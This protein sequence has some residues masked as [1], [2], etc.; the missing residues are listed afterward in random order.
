MISILWFYF[1]LSD[2]VIQRQQSDLLF[3]LYNISY[4]IEILSLKKLACASRCNNK[5]TAFIMNLM[6]TKLLSLF[7]QS[8][9]QWCP[10]NCTIIF[11]SSSS[12]L[13]DSCASDFIPVCLS[14]IIAN[15]LLRQMI[16][17]HTIWNYIKR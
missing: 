9:G 10:R 16:D 1:L 3:L 17:C 4:Y 14:V 15:N 2:P 5:L 8:L 7:V 12:R 13:L 11:I 6:L